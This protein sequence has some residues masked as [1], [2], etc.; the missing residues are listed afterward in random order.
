[1]LKLL[2]LI[3]TIFKSFTNPDSKFAKRAGAIFERTGIDMIKII[4]SQL[5]GG[6]S[7]FKTLNIA[8]FKPTEAQFFYDVITATLRER[9]RVKIRRNDLVDMILD[10]AKDPDQQTEQ[11]EE[12]S[13]SKL[14]HIAGIREFDELTVVSTALVLL[15]AGYDSTAQTMSYMAHELAKHPDI[16][17]RYVL[18]LS[19][20]ILIIIILLLSQVNE[21]KR[22]EMVIIFTQPFLSVCLSVRGKK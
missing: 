9:E 10:A 21:A 16:Q 13:D 2:T 5:P 7:L 8:N 20:A 22:N 12:C 3:I 17:K 15:V 18:F 4:L 19:S 6:L 14:N 1:M 11:M